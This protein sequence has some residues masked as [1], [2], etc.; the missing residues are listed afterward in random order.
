MDD[1]GAGYSG[2][3]TL[4]ALTPDYVKVDMSIVRGI[5]QDANRQSLFSHFVSYAR[6]C[7]IQVIAEGVETEA[8]LRTLI[9]LGADYLQ[10]YYLGTPNPQ[11]SQVDSSIVELIRATARQPRAPGAGAG[12]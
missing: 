8:E 9:E 12:T 10:G 6:S 1:F 4:L 7:G 5:D 3:S 2:E 11:P